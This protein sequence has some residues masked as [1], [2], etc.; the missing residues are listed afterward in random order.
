M[1][2]IPWKGEG[3]DPNV[4]CASLPEHMSWFTLRSRHLFVRSRYEDL[5]RVVDEK[6]C[7]CKDTE[8]PN[9]FQRILLLGNTGIGKTVALN[10]FLVR[11]L[12][13][14]YRVLFETRE[15]RYYFHD[16]TM[17]WED[18]LESGLRHH[19]SFPDVLFLVDHEIG[20][21]PPC[22]PAFTVAPVSPDP[23]N[24]GEFKK[25][26]VLRLWMPLTSREELVAMNS[27]EP[28]FDE[29]KLEE[30]LQEFGPIPRL[31]F[32][33]DDGLRGNRV[34]LSG[35]IK[36]FDFLRCQQSGMLLSG[37]LPEDKGGLS[38]WILHVT[39][40]DLRAPSKISWATHGIMN[41]V[42]EKFQ[43]RYLIQ[44]ESQIASLLSN[45]GALHSPDGEFEYWA[46]HV[47]ASGRDLQLFSPRYQG[48]KCVLDS[49]GDVVKLPPKDVVLIR[50]IADVSVLVQN[51]G[52]VYYSQHQSEPLCDAAAVENKELL[53]FQMTIGKDHSFKEQTWRQYCKA[54][55]TANLTRVRFIFVVPHQ[56]N[57]CVSQAQVRLFES[58]FGIPT[59]LHVAEL[60]PNDTPK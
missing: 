11:A 16:D 30:R 38:W 54:A 32:A 51:T 55:K 53:L 35:K 48:G 47:I 43:G 8:L 57:F 9:S 50:T 6:F 5:W 37:E 58:D 2:P 52:V 49:S 46:C 23:A 56:G 29:N 44:L 39:T 15:M 27:I 24:Y 10:Y 17:E 22:V 12:Q 7:I 28:M 3:D 14:N 42:L 4:L 34:D 33:D 13:K 40:R 45:P 21:S 41:K 1:E 31:V 19:R 59:S 18:I 36:S 25:N 20:K 60:R 26:R